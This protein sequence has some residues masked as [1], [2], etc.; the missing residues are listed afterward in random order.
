MAVVGTVVRLW[1]RLWSSPPLT[2]NGWVA[3]NLPRTVTAVGVVLL[4]AI[5]VVHGYL[6]ASQPA[7]PTYFIVY[8]VV[9]AVGCIAAVVAVALTQW[10]WY[11]GSLVCVAF[12]GIYLVSRM[13]SLPGLEALTGRWD[14]A[15][16]TFAMAF[17]A[18]FIAVH[19]TVLSGI[20][21]AYPQ[22]QGWHD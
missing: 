15:P 16:G 22:Q 10:G 8:A 6:A 2:L 12:L 7:L 1:R 13:V 3:F 4:V 18:G 17:A 19:A 20:N 9:L 14:V 5:V 11:L 21:V